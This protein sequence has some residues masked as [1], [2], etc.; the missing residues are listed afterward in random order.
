MHN[1]NKNTRR[2]SCKF[3]N[4]KIIIWAL[5]DDAESSYKKAVQKYYKQFNNLEVHSIGIN[6]ISFK[7]KEKF[8]YHKIDLSIQNFNLLKQLKELPKPDIILASPPCE[9]WSNADCNGKMLRSISEDGHWIV[10]NRKHYDEYNTKCNPVKHR[11]FLQ[12]ERGRLI[13]EGTISGTVSIIEKFKPKVWIIEN[14][15]TSKSWEYQRNHLNFLGYENNT[16]YSSYDNNFS[17]KPTTFKSNIELNLL[18]KRQKGN[19]NHMARGS[20][21]KRS[22][23]PKELIAD[24]LNQIF[25]FLK[26]PIF[27]KWKENYE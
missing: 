25:Q 22:A 5:F 14:P 15:T 12:K 9:S 1:V 13:G 17:L 6:D 11:F 7:E 24:V 18:K 21:S 2:E 27:A 4:S 8:F 23:I 3:S 19:N 20:Y 16:Y 10:M 26:K